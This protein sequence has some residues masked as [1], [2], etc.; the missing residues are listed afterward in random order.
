M[1]RHFFNNDFS[2]DVIY[3]KMSKIMKELDEERKKGEGN[4]D[5]EKERELIYAQ[6]IQGLKL[7]TLSTNRNFY[8]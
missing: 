3:E 1:D 6:W 2:K 4:I 7:N 5:L 8:F